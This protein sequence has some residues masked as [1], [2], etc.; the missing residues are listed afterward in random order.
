[1]NGIESVREREAVGCWQISC[2][3]R[4]KCNL[5][6][7]ICDVVIVMRTTHKSTALELYEEQPSER[8]LRQRARGEGGS[9]RKR[10]MRDARCEHFYG[11]NVTIWMYVF[12]N[13]CRRNS[14]VSLDAICRFQIL[15][16]VVLYMRICILLA[17]AQITS[18][19]CSTILTIFVLVLFEH[20]VIIIT[21]SEKQE[22]PQ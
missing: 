20:P 21:S 10:E 13:I 8:R 15:G 14:L 11:S 3:S 9:G 17:L 5:P 7:R 2:Y 4:T 1:M 12:R 6:E 19:D 16:C 22:N 18:S